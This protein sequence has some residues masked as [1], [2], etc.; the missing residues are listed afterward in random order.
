[1]NTYDLFKNNCNNFSDTCAN[2][3]VGESIPSY[4]LNL[5]NEVLN[6]QMGQTFRPF[7]DNF[8]N[9]LN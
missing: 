3:L 2:F 4:I 6:T 8:Q 1:M 7:I 9:Q 5:P